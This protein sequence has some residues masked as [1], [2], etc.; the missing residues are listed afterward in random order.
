MSDFIKNI[1]KLAKEYR[2]SEQDARFSQRYA[3]IITA[4]PS[5]DIKRLVY[6]IDKSITEDIKRFGVSRGFANSGFVFHHMRYPE[7]NG[8]IY[9]NISYDEIKKIREAVQI[10]E[11]DKVISIQV[12]RSSF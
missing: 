11:N 6:R 5:T 4:Y 1:V 8:V 10:Y 12:Y 3:K 9:S 7:N 2:A